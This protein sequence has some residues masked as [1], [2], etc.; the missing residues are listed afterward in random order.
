MQGIWSMSVPS[1]AK[2]GIT[3]EAFTFRR[4]PYRQI[5]WGF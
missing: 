3:D 4:S 2:G 1:N 5:T